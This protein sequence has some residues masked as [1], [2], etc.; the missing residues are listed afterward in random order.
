MK[1][2]KKRKSHAF[3][4]DIYLLGKFRSGEYF[5]L[6]AARWDCGWYWG[7]GY[8]E[9]YTNNKCPDQA[10]DISSHSHVS[11]LINTTVDGNYI[12]RLYDN[13]RI[14]ECVLSEDEDWEFS[15]LMKQFYI[16]REAADLFHQQD[17]KI[18]ETLNQKKLPPIF[19]KIYN[20]LSP[21]ELK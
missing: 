10:R 14:T 12:H 6:E 1:I 7:F 18:W 19:E 20:L 5:W 2:I 21:G 16:I 9:C 11:G 17:K 8:V 13:P 3:G 15:S 4:K